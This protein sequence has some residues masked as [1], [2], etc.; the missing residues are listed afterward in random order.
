MTREPRPRVSCRLN[1][2]MQHG[3]YIDI[4][5]RGSSQDEK[6]IQK[7]ALLMLSLSIMRR[8]AKEGD[9]PMASCIN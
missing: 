5:T 9:R 6:N 3:G 2:M 1:S 7:R 4:Y 8:S